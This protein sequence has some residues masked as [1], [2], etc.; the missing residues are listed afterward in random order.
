M[1]LKAW[2]NCLSPELFA[3]FQFDIAALIPELSASKEHA[4]WLLQL[5]LYQEI[6]HEMLS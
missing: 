3:S 1:V 4:R 2:W 5:L 6:K